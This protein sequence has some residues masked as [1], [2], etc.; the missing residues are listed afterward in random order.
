MN[1]L[2]KCKRMVVLFFFFCLKVNVRYDVNDNIVSLDYV[3]FFFFFFSL[4]GR[5]L[6]VH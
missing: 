4:S 2:E 3:F 6:G 5:L 1:E